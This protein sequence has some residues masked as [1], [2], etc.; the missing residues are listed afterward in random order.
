LNTSGRYHRGLDFF[1]TGETW[2]ALYTSLGPEIAIWEMVR[3]SAARNLAHL[4]NNALTEIEVDLAHVLDLSDPALVGLTLDDLTGTDLR[5]CQ[6]QAAA[7]IGRG[8]QGLL[9]PSA[10]IPGLN[11]VIFTQTLSEPPPLRV[12]QSAELPLGVAAPE[13]HP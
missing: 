13:L 8:S 11:L 9:V 7:A 10:A 6:D 5:P 1:P 3:R 4:W 2:L 12:V